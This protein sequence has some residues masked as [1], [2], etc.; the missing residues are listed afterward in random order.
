MR[1]QEEESDEQESERKPRVNGKEEKFG[2]Q[3]ETEKRKK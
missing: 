2:Y 1:Q 3:E